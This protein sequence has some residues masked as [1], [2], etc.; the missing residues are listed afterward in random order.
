[1]AL[2][3]KIGGL[4]AAIGAS[5]MAGVASA[6]T[7]SLREGLDVIGVPVPGG[8]NFQPGVTELANDIRALDNF[9]LVIVTLIVLFVTALLA[10]TIIRHNARANPELP[11]TYPNRRKRI[12]PSIV[13]IL[14]VKTPANVPRFPP[15]AFDFSVLL[16]FCIWD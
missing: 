16:I 1:M 9:L 8:V 12:M 5:L 13:R 7:T 11:T 15:V 10:W 3:T 4:W 6:Q 2:R 14:G